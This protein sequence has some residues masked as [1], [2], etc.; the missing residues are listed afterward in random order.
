[1]REL[2]TLQGMVLSAMPIGDFDKRLV[3]LTKERGKITAFARGIRKPNSNLLAAGNPFCFGRFS[4]YEGKNAYTLVQAEIQNYFREL[5]ADFEGA[6]YGF[7]FMEFA[8]YYTRENNDEAQM[9]NLLY[10]SLRALLNPHLNQ[11]L[12]RSVFELKAMVLN[13]EYPE[14][15]SCVECGRTEQ[16]ER[17]SLRKNG[18][19]C[20]SCRREAGERELL[21]STLYALQYVIA[22]PLEKLY[23][24]TLSKEVQKEFQKVI[25]EFRQKYIEKQF[26]SLD[27]LQG[28]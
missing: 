11:E 20:R 2:L 7:Y 27:I 6:C 17:F 22:V 25:G 10:V 14:V 13:G 24:F 8:D 26:K 23:T 4:L 15:F 12:V 28:L 18:M 21:D 16:L 3:I 19:I 9:L 1:M 5:A